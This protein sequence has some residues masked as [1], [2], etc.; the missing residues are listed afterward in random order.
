[1]FGNIRELE[2]I[3]E[4][5]VIL[6]SGQALQVSPVCESSRRHVWGLYMALM[7]FENQ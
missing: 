4:R 1:M 2:N 7:M 6:S 3:M 5:A